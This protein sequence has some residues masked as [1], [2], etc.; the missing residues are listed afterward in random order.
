LS[1]YG[2]ADGLST[3]AEQF[4]VQLTGVLSTI[5]FTAVAT[6]V[7]LKLVSVLT[8]GLRVDEEEEQQGLDVVS[9]EETGYNL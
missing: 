6:Y 8:N 1:G 3:I 9:H 5:A 2:F 7:I 4:S